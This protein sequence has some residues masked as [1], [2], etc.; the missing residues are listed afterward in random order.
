MEYLIRKILEVDES[1]ATPDVLSRDIYEYANKTF[2]ANVLGIKLFYILEKITKENLEKL[3]NDEMTISELFNT[4]LYKCSDKLILLRQYATDNKE[5]FV[6]SGIRTYVC[7]R[8][9]VRDQTIDEK[10]TRSLDEG[11]T[12]K[13]TCNNCG[14]KWNAN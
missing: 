1:Y 6:A 11:V 3:K 13:C 2:N 9:K 5:I 12:I 7:P 4:S 10:Q 8:C 14:K